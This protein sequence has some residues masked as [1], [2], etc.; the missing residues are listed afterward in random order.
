MWRNTTSHEQD[1]SDWKISRL[2]QYSEDLESCGDRRDRHT[3]KTV[4]RI[5]EEKQ[6]EWRKYRET[7]KK[8][9]EERSKI[10]LENVEITE[11]IIE[12]FELETQIPGFKVKYQNNVSDNDIRVLLG[13]ITNG[14]KNGVETG[15][16]Q[17]KV[18]I[19]ILQIINRRIE[20]S[21]LD[22]NRRTQEAAVSA[23]R[24]VDEFTAEHKDKKL[25]L[26][27]KSRLSSL[28]KD[29][30]YANGDVELRKE[31]T[32]KRKPITLESVKLWTS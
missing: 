22:W 16:R 20:T 7:L 13:A 9:R 6:E 21:V 30:R 17:E 12:L 10:Q 2:K 3:I 31:M 29:L 19:K 15:A 18:L 8:A 24:A 26:I 14:Y 32:E 27:E 11:E 4:R 1:F 25:S 23:Q 28:E 5:L